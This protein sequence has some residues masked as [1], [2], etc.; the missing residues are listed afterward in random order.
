MSVFTCEG[1]DD[2]AVIHREEPRLPSE[3]EDGEAEMYYVDEDEDE[4]EDEAAGEDCIVCDSLD[5]QQA[6]DHDE[7]KD[8]NEDRAAPVNIEANPQTSCDD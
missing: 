4:D 5:N 3:D 8:S 6:Q 2:G 7:D 1:A